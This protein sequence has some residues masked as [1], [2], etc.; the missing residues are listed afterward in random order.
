MVEQHKTNTLHACI[1]QEIHSIDV[2]ENSEDRR[3]TA[4]ISSINRNDEK[5]EADQDTACFCLDT[6]KNN[7]RRFDIHGIYALLFIM[8]NEPS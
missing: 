6:I 3:E 5:E 2:A 1:Q 4:L 7:F 8:M